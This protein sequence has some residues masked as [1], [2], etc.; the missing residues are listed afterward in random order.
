M[1]APRAIRSCWLSWAAVSAAD[2]RDVTAHLALADLENISWARGIEL[3]DMIA[4]RAEARWSSMLVTPP[5]EGWV[6]MVGPWWTLSDLARTTHVTDVCADLSARFGRAQVYFHGEQGDGEA[7]L[8]AERGTMTRRWISEYPELALGEPCGLE[9]RSL[10]A[11]GIAGQPEDL[12]P[13]DDDQAELLWAWECDALSIAAEASLD[14][15]RIGP[16]TS[17]PGP[18]M[19]TRPPRSKNETRSLTP[20]RHGRPSRL[21]RRPDNHSSRCQQSWPGANYRASA[22]NPEYVHS[23]GR[24]HSIPL[25]GILMP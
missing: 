15:R 14:P 3:I 2:H 22:Q 11:A 5:I 19:V 20:P 10:D 8:L 1:D 18:L 13:D 6:L 4:H 23:V 25:S 12:D 9:R 7:W 24:W 21:T 17:T 16:S